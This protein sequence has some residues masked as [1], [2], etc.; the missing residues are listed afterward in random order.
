MEVVVVMV[1]KGG[2]QGVGEWGGGLLLKRRSSHKNTAEPKIEDNLS[3]TRYF[4]V[5]K[6]QSPDCVI[7]GECLTSLAPPVSSTPS[8]SLWGHILNLLDWLLLLCMC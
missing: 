6:T 4:H 3:E 7:S 8:S 5:Y 1:G 2:E